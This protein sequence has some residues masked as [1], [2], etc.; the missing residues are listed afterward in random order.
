EDE[1]GESIGTA[2]SHSVVDHGRSE[3]GMAGTEAAALLTD[4]ELAFTLEDQVNFVGAGV[5]VRLLRLSGFEAVDVAE[6]SRRLEQVDLLHLF[7]AEPL[8]RRD[9]PDLHQIGSLPA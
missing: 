3:D 2:V 6:H 7:G 4:G 1:Q 9:R 8:E 5:S